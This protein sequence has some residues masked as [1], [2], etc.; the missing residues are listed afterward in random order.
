[1]AQATPPAVPTT[2]TN[3]AKTK[4]YLDFLCA[5]EQPVEVRDLIGF[6][7]YKGR[8]KNTVAVISANLEEM[9]LRTV[10][11]FDVGGLDSYVLLQ[12]VNTNDLP[13]VSAEHPDDHLLTLTRIPSAAFAQPRPNATSD[14]AVGYVYRDTPIAN[15]LTVM[16]RHDFSQLPVVDS[17]S[18]RT[19]V[20]V[21]TWESYALARLRG[22]DPGRVGDAI[23]ATSA[24]DLHSDLFASVGPVADQ[25][26][27]LVTFQGVL[28]GIVTAS[29]LTREFEKLT[30][31][32]LAIG[33]CE[34]ELRRVARG[35]LPQQVAETRKPFDS[36]TFGD[37]QTFFKNNWS[38]LGWS[39]SQAEFDGWLDSAR[40]LRNSIA[41]F[42]N[43][44]ENPTAELGAVH[45]L[46]KW[47]RSVPTNTN[48]TFAGSEVDNDPS[49][50]SPAFALN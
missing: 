7:G 15:A 43:Q 3:L 31:P 20:G 22:E 2:S 5:A 42:D 4:E 24:V 35:K 18:R 19:V 46:T 6:W 48:P 13:E 14:Q 16:L 50:R 25:G 10:P 32:F 36:Y 30:L 26:Y 23:V 1:L 40:R 28:S 38:L 17:G 12:K 27:V 9:E 44:D 39:L 41:H 29:D 21:F 37:L 34:Q 11:P 33:R 47:L 45:R 8:G 49:V